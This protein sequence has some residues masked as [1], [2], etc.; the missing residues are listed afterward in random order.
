MEQADPNDM[1]FEVTAIDEEE[2]SMYA[3]ATAVGLK[4]M[5]TTGITTS[6]PSNNIEVDGNGSSMPS[7]LP[8]ATRTEVKHDITSTD[9]ER[10]P[11]PFPSATKTDQLQEIHQRILQ[12]PKEIRNIIA[13]GLA[14]MIAKSVVAPFDRIKILY[15]VSSAQ[16][17]ITHLPSIAKKIV[18][19]EGVKALWKGNTATLIRVFPYSG[20]QFMVFDRCKTFLLREQESQFLKEKAIN[21]QTPKPKWGLSPIES[22]FAGMTAGAVSVIATYPLDLTRA[23]LAVLKTKKGPDNIGF[24]GALYGNYKNRGVLGLFRG[25]T[26]TLMGILPYSGLAFAFN[27]Q[28]KRKIQSMTGREV[29]TIERMQ[30]GALSGLLAQT[31]TYPLEVTRRRMQTI[32]IV[33]TSGKDAAID[34][35][36]Q[37]HGRNPT[38]ET[39][40]RALHP[41]H[42]PTMGAIVK[43]LY[44]EQG[45]RGFFKGVS[46][47]WFKGPL[48]F[49]ISFT[50]FD[51][52]QSKMETAEERRLRMPRRRST[53]T[54]VKK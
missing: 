24:A 5:S 42:P 7:S 43:E 18:E 41:D 33:A 28:T 10:C 21:P 47:N 38:A 9:T 25:I 48:A 4:S 53:V 23:Q 19:T 40:I 44:L 49:S 20:I 30:C 17:H 29:T 34:I 50:V 8:A 11:A 3:D 15:Q 31:L 45:I 1:S 16:F 2:S 6:I 13:G 14:G 51:M 37:P 46:M 36:G 22:L 26:P 35:I 39:A 54:V 27:E 52:L 32:G 12:W